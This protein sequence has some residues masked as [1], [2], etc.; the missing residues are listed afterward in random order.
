MLAIV[1]FGRY[2]TN[3]LWLLSTCEVIPIVWNRSTLRKTSRSVSFC[4]EISHGTSP[5]LYDDSPTPK[6]PSRDN[7]TCWFLIICNWKFWAFFVDFCTSYVAIGNGTGRK[8]VNSYL[9]QLTPLSTFVLEKLPVAELRKFTDF[10]GTELSIRG[11][12]L[13]SFWNV[14]WA[15]LM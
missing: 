9:Y 4:T 7:T 1:K 5:V 11:S 13:D 2:T 6:R 3:Q 10:H 15:R 8:F 14:V 12:L